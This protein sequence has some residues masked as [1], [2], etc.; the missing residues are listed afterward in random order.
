MSRY[1]DPKTDVVFKKIFGEHPHLLMSFLNAVL[2]LPDDQPIVEVIYLPVE[3]IPQIPAFKRTVV[4]VKCKDSHGRV[5]IVEMQISWEHTFRQRLLFGASQAVVKQLEKGEDYHFY[6]PV[7]GLGLVADTFD[8]N[9]D[10]WYHH[11]QLVEQAGNHHVIEQLQLV[12]IELPKFPVQTTTDKKLRILWLR[13]LREIN[14]TINQ[15]PQ[16]LLDV[17]EIYEAVKL[18]EEA[19][20][21]SGELDAYN[22]YWLSIKRE[23]A[24]LHAANEK[25]LKQGLEQG[26]EQGLKQGELKGKIETAKAM[27]ELGIDIQLILQAT[28][29][30]KEQIYN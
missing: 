6:E 11:Y 22:S 10:E 1:L 18:A 25:G 9:S 5:F 23:N 15:A 12:F 4:D 14:R 28:Q 30:T 8:K 3:Q 24:I 20:Y 27:L 16:D 13:F 7:Y 26:L 2:P 19:A 21:T 29:L 17:P